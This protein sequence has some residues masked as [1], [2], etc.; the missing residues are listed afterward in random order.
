MG[1]TTVRHLRHFFAMS[2]A[3]NYHKIGQRFTVLFKK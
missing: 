1:Y 3:K 2:S